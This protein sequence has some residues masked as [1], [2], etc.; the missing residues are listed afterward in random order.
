MNATTVRIDFPAGGLSTY[1]ID[2][3]STIMVTVPFS[4]LRSNVSLVVQ[5]PFVIRATAGGAQLNTPY[6]QNKE[7]DM[8]A[9]LVTNYIL[10]DLDVGSDQW[11]TA[12]GTDTTIS[13]SF[14]Q[15]FIS[16]QNED[17]GWNKIVR[18]ALT[19]SMLTR[20]TAE[21]VRLSFGSFPDY[22]IAEPEAI[23]LVVPA[24]ALRSGRPVL[25]GGAAYV[26][27]PDRGSAD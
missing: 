6:T 8:R 12:V 26:I 16:A 7:T 3:P 25:A 15:G 13:T 27:I 21:R 11:S 23:Y 18:P 20:V 19:I 4:A 10:I 5:P 24:T 1:D 2:A 14:L 9:S 22:N 17:Y